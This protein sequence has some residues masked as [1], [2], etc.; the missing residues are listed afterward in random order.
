MVPRAVRAP[1]DT[2]PLVAKAR[3]GGLGGRWD[4]R[5][6]SAVR[7]FHASMTPSDPTGL[8][9]FRGIVRKISLHDDARFVFRR[10]GFHEL[11]KSRCLVKSALLWGA[12]MES[13]RTAQCMAIGGAP[14]PDVCNAALE[15]QG[16]DSASERV[17]I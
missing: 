16:F 17:R 6:A 7:S 14:V 5:R 10:P 9:G 1:V 11:S 15:Q 3:P 2:T 8:E 12:P 4:D 13:E